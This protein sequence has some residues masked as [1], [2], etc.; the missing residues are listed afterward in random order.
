LEAAQARVCGARG[1]L[2][3]PRDCR[4]DECVT[5]LREALGYLEWLRDNLA[6]HSLALVVQS[7][8]GL[9]AQT[10][11]VAL[12]IRQAG[13]LLDQA[14]RR[15]RHWLERLQAA[16]GYTSDGAAVP[17]APRGRISFFG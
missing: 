7:R 13:I 17:L 16:S 4:L 2:A 14:A 1:L 6:D 15:G 10:V 5:Q 11:A 9:R 3:H 12:E 8:R